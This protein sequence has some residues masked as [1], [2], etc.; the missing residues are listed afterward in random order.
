MK[1]RKIKNPITPGEAKR[2]TKAVRGEWI[3]IPPQTGLGWMGQWIM[4]S[5]AWEFY[6]NNKRWPTR[7]KKDSI[8]VRGR[9]ISV[10]MI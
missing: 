10:D 2:Y 1:K 6:K 7:L 8:V 3:D 5:L 4:A 9:N